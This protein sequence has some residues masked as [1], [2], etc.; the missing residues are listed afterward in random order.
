MGLLDEA[1]ETE[2]PRRGHRWAYVMVRFC[3]RSG[4]GLKL[5]EGILDILDGGKA[6]GRS[7]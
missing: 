5:S 4:V 6:I 7:F 3:G 2:Q 1:D